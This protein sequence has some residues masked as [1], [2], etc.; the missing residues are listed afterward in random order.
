ML[1]RIR[2]SGALGRAMTTATVA[3]TSDRSTKKCATRKPSSAFSALFGRTLVEVAECIVQSLSQR[4]F[5]DRR[6]VRRGGGRHVGGPVRPLP[7]S[8]GDA[9][10]ADRAYDI[11]QQPRES[12]E[13]LVGRLEQDGVAVLRDERRPH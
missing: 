7:A 1:M 5:L 13:A 9:A 10:G 4:R 6:R 12:V 2:C 8:E 11:R 3:A